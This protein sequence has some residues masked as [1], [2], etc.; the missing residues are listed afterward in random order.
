MSGYYSLLLKRLMLFVLALFTGF[1][2][3]FAQ[4][5]QYNGGAGYSTGSYY[6]NEQTSTLHLSNGL[7][8]GFKR[9]RVSYLSLQ[10]LLCPL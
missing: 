5:I 6:F 9:V 10:T 8:A 7:S 3:G 1:S 2:L 4:E